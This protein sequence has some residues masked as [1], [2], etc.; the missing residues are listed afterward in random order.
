VPFPLGSPVGEPGNE[1]KQ[2]EVIKATLKLLESVEEP[3]KIVNLPFQ[4]REEP[5]MK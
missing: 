4:W 1:E 3:G 2:L 5:L